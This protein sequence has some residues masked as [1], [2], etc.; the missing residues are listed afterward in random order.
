VSAIGITTCAIAAAVALAF[1]DKLSHAAP[2]SASGPVPA[3]VSSE[4]EP[5]SLPWAVDELKEPTLFQSVG[6]VLDLLMIAHEVPVAAF[7]PSQSLGWA[8][9]ICARPAAG[10]DQCPPDPNPDTNEYGGARIQVDPGDTLKIRMV[11]QL[12]MFTLGI[13]PHNPTRPTNARS[14]NPI[15]LHTHGL[16]VSPHYAQ[17]PSSIWGDNPF[18]RVFNSANGPAPDFEQMMGPVLYDHID[19]EYDMPGTHPS[20]LFWFHPHAHGLTQAQIT[21]GLA[22]E[23]TVGHVA[24]EVCAVNDSSC[25]AQLATMP[26]RNLLFKDTQIESDGSVARDE[27]TGFCAVDDSVGSTSPVHQGGCD[28]SAVS[29]VSGLNHVGGRWVYPINGQVYPTLTVGMP[30]GQIWRLVNA[31]S[32]TTYDLQLYLPNEQRQMAMQVLWVDGVNVGTGASAAQ[33]KAHASMLDPINCPSGLGGTG[34]CT[35]RVHIMPAMRA[36]LW[37]GYRDASGALVPN[38]APTPVILRTPGYNTGPVGDNY[39]AIDLAKVDFATGQVAMHGDGRISA[40]KV[41]PPVAQIA[42]NAFSMPKDALCGPLPAGHTRRIFLNLTQ[43]VPTTQFGLGYEELDENGTPVPGTFV[44]VR[45]F[46]HMDEPLC[47]SLK[48]GNQ[49]EVERWQLVNLAQ[50]DHSF[51]V[52]QVRFKVIDAPPVDGTITPIS[53]GQQI[54]YVDSIPLAHADG[55]CNTV[56]DWRNG[57]CTAHVATIEIPFTI[58]GDFIFHCHVLEHE[59]GGMMAGIRVLPESSLGD[60]IFMDGFDAGAAMKANAMHTMSMQH[61]NGGMQWNHAEKPQKRLAARVK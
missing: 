33:Q 23:L 5:P 18:A 30:T 40:H 11:N 51:H 42:G 26:E 44:D 38:P 12:P 36:E 39:P 59:D 55:V 27:D 54:Q 16:L 7:A 41:T 56:D 24:D 31:S 60:R 10:N 45:K 48:P 25:E 58:A 49:P 19:Y 3:A 61:H 32:N 14:Q 22:G 15:S 13:D 29:P 8:Y 53:I 46:S 50:E 35:T 57:A 1:S 21:S 9:Q 37:I 2:A 6:G 47:L 20:G 52:H 17:P 28:G 34:L 43:S 4:S